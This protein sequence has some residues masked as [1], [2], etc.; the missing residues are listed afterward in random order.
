MQKIVDIFPKLDENTEIVL[1][2][3]NAVSTLEG[4]TLSCKNIMILLP[5]YINFI[6]IYFLKIKPQ[7]NRGRLYS[8]LFLINNISIANIIAVL[9]NIKEET[10]FIIP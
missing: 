5:K 3:S 4:I 2:T 9:K 1:C 6:N 8:N 10:L 7:S